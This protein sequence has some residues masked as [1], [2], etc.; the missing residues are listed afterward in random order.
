MAVPAAAG[1]AAAA[2]RAAARLE[3]TPA[4]NQSLEA[5]PCVAPL[6]GRTPE[7]GRSP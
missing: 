5:S 3:G 7:R 6:P 1:C 4:S 2:A